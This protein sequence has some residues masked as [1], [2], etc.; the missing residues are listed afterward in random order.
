VARKSDRPGLLDLEEL[1]PERREND[2]NRLFGGIARRVVRVPPTPYLNAG[3]VALWGFEAGSARLVEGGQN[4]GCSVVIVCHE[5]MY[6][7]GG[8][9]FPATIK[10]ARRRPDR[11]QPRDAPER[12]ERQ[13]RF[14]LLQ[15]KSL[16]APT[17]SQSVTERST[18]SM[19]HR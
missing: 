7:R 19:I 8:R 18:A 3:A 2:R 6:S 11:R 13:G 4:G 16:A 17:F 5:W 14:F 9:S 1:R 12:L 15:A 10:S